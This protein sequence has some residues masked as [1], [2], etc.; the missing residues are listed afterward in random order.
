MAQ[1]LLVRHGQASFGASD[2]DKLSDLGVD[3]SRALGR[4]W[5]QSGLGIDSMV[6]GDM[7]R[8]RET[9]DG[10]REAFPDA[11]ELHIDSGFNEY[12]FQDVMLRYR[13]DFAEGGVMRRLVAEKSNPKQAFQEL[14]SQATARWMDA[15]DSGEYEESWPAFRD[16]VVAAARRIIEDDSR[17]VTAVFTS[18]GPIG[19]LVQWVLGLD[20]LQ[21]QSLNWVIANSSVTGVIYRPGQISLSYFNNFAHLQQTGDR[22]FISYR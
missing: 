4:W 6:S 14:F 16:R 7:L 9:A 19:A 11:T 13:P 18:G 1:L 10:V 3:Q 17:R 8:H 20:N 12:D 15:G 2:Y 21:M 5:A 22:S